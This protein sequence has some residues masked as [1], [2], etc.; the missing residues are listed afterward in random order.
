M[1]E[2]LKPFFPNPE[3]EPQH[4]KH[5]SLHKIENKVEIND[6]QQITAR[7]PGLKKFLRH[8]NSMS[9]I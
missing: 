4:L 3:D 9:S 2:N 5:V 6:Q 7:F 8:K 1:E